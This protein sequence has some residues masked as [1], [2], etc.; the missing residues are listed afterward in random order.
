MDK[1]KVKFE[2]D[3]GREFYADEVGIIHNPMRILFDFRSITPRIDMRNKEFQPLV[4]RHNLV[5]MDPYTAKQF[6]DILK[7]NIKN[8]EEK[9]GKIKKPDALSKIEKE[10]KKESKGKGKKVQPTYFG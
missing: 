1:N 6:M 5:M 9:F 7:S 2:I 3:N 10:A 4:L 8:Y